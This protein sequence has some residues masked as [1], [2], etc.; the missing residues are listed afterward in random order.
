MEASPMNKMRTA[1]FC[2]TIYAALLT[3][4]VMGVAHSGAAY[5]SAPLF[6]HAWA[7]EMQESK[8]GN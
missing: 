8:V 7:K 5:L 6:M 3:G 4:Y 1:L 2:V